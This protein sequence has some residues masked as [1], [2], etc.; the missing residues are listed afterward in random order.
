MLPVI[1]WMLLRAITSLSA[2]IVS[3]IKPMTQLEVNIPFFPPSAPIIQ[4]LERAFVSPLMRW[5]ALWYQR[6]VTQGYSV[7]DGTAQFHPLYPWMAVPLSRIG[8]A[9]TLSLLI[10]SALAGIALFYFFLKLARY[11][12][13]PKDANFALLLFVLAPP[14]FILFTPYSEGLFLLTAVLCMIFLRQKSWWLAGLMG[15]LATLTRQQGIFLLIPMAWE[16][17]EDGDRKLASIRRQWRDWFALIIIFLGMLLWLL[18]RALILND[19]KVNLSNFQEFIYSTI[20]S[21]SATKVVTNQ[22]FIWP[23]LA[24]KFTFIKL[25]T[26]S[27]LDIWVNIVFGAIFLILLGIT[28]RKMRVSYRLYSLAISLV[29]FSYYTGPTHPYMGLLRHLFLAF[30]V[31]IGLAVLIKN[32][33]VRLILIGISI[34][35]FLFL[36]TLYVLQTWVP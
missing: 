22:Q 15:G 10:V 7:S 29:S 9:P 16:L 11:D 18:Y 8:L 28:W 36:L 33:W 26:Q 6:I 27:D 17:W 19:L 35:A 23:W 1:V 25:L 4:W 12:L 13:P 5:D 32:R 21:P 3:S 20:V 30:P 2:G 14:A 34:F 31:F 24:L